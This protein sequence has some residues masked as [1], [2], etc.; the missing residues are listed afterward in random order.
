MAGRTLVAGV[1]SSTQS[2]KVVVRDADTGA[3]VRHGRAAHPPGTEVHPA[4]WEE[5]LS[6]A[7]AEAGGLD[8]FGCNPYGLPARRC[9]ARPGQSPGPSHSA[10]CR[11][12][13]DIADRRHRADPT[14]PP[15]PAISRDQLSAGMVPWRL[16]TATI[17][18]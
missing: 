15:N 3:L 18:Q 17:L 4:A 13:F 7:L 10:L 5:A 16:R 2:C 11:F 6:T 12:R 8:W 14:Y 1:D 9:R